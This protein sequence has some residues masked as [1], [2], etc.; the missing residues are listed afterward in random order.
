MGKG[1]V[2]IVSMDATRDD[3]IRLARELRHEFMV[4]LDVEARG[5]NAQMK[6]A[7]KSGARVAV[8]L[9]EDEWRRGEVSVKDLGTGEQ[10]A[11]AREVLNQSLRAILSGT[12]SA[13]AGRGA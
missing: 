5:F 3:A 6:A 12:G 1:G 13:A 4:E 10:R 7:G 8:I 2:F 11:V 9:G